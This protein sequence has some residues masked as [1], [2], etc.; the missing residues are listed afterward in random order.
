MITELQDEHNH[1][2]RS[3]SENNDLKFDDHVSFSAS[4]NDAIFQN[5]EPQNGRQEEHLAFSS[6]NSSSALLR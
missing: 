3:I 4:K 1:F 5:G 6:S 2:I